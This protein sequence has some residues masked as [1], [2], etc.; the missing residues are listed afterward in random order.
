MWSKMLNI[1][2]L[3]TGPD[4]SFLYSAF[5]RAS[6]KKKAKASLMNKHV[7]Q[8]QLQALTTTSNHMNIHQTA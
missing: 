6:Q 1:Q 4:I 8:S 5:V 2:Q 3:L 7:G